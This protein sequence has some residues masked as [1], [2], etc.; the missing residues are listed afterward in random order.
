[1]YIP[2]RGSA[3]RLFFIPLIFAV[4]AMIG[5]TI[6]VVVMT[7]ILGEPDVDPTAPIVSESS[8]SPAAK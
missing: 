1:M 6:G 4:L 2:F 7:A 8:N 5:A 3:L